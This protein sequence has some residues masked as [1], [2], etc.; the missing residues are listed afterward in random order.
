M[1][2][3]NA[4]RASL[5]LGFFLCSTVWAQKYTLSGYIRDAKSG[6]PLI[7]ATVYAP[8]LKAG[9]LANRYGFYSLTLPQTDQLRLVLSFVG[10]QVQVKTLKLD[11]DIRLNVDLQEDAGSETVEVSAERAEQITETARMGTMDIPIAQ[12]KKVPTILG[13]T[14]VLKALQLLPGVKGGV[15]GSSGLYVRGGGPDQNLLL[16]DG[17]PV[18]NASHLLGFFSVFNADAIQHVELTKGGFPARYGGRLSSVVDISMKE[19]NLKQTE[20]E[21]GIGLISSRLTIQSP[22]VRDKASF[23]VSG[24][25]TYAD[26]VARPLIALAAAQ[27]NSPALDF[28]LYFYDLNAKL[29]AI[30]SP[31]DRLYLSTY[32]GKDLFYNKFSEDTGSSSSFKTGGGINWGNLTTTLRWN[33]LFSNRLFANT[34]LLFSR[35]QFNVGVEN[36]QSQTMDNQV[37]RSFQKASYQSGIQDWS[38]RTDL[39]YLPNPVHRFKFGGLYT[40]HTYNPGV[41]AARFEETGSAPKDT[42]LIPKQSTFIGH[43]FNIYAEDDWTISPQFKVNLGVH[44][45]GFVMDKTFFPSLQPRI[46]LRYLIGKTAFKASFVTMQQYLHLLTNSGIGLPTDLWLPA[47]PSVKPAQAWQAA[48]GLARTF[49]QDAFELSIEGYYKSMKN[50]VEYKE[51]ASFLTDPTKDWQTKVTQGKGLAYGLEVFLQKKTGRTTGWL[52]YTLAWS[53][54]T[55]AELNK[56]ETFPFRYD[57]RHDFSVVLAHKFN[58]RVDVGLNWVY[59]TGNSVTLAQSQYMALPMITDFTQ[60][61]TVNDWNP[62]GTGIHTDY[63]KRNSFKLAAY[64]RLDF[65]INVHRAKASRLLGK[66]ERVW[67]FSA[68]N[69]YNRKNPFFVYLGYTPVYKTN[70]AGERVYDHTLRQFKQVSLIPIVPVATYSFKF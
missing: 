46:A 63:G 59:G 27:S 54:R 47:T 17:A 11:Q 55:F 10:Y 67:S 29:N 8:A 4:L 48:L 2:Y 62:F 1:F 65:S 21:G 18:Y 22:I 40:Y 39:D 32:L 53:D 12:L 38:L 36:E 30:L 60:L 52:G 64:H 49:A 50:L 26:V 44:A 3:S 15:E 25:R 43:E 14:D 70:A 41:A 66:G 33:H 58:E 51:G 56:G 9:T 57:R 20:V 69:A 37:Y 35:Y 13:E 16:L 45:S 42:L 28:R 23:I 24:R 68:Y 61:F 5:C 6:E 19:G 31:K 34:M 7:G